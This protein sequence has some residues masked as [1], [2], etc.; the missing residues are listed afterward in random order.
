MIEVL[1]NYIVFNLFI[2]LCTVVAVAAVDKTFYKVK[3]GITNEN[4]KWSLPI[5]ALLF[6]VIFYWSFES[7][8]GSPLSSSHIIFNG[9][10]IGAFSTVF[11]KVIKEALI[12]KITRRFQ[13][14]SGE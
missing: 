3:D 1:Q 11:Y 9:L 7:M 13:D 12:K 14:L 8:E 2:V 4:R 6:G 5:L 10:N